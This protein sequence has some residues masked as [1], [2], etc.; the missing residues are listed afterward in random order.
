MLEAA[1]GVGLASVLAV[2]GLWSD[3]D[4]DKVFVEGC[5]DKER[6]YNV[7]SE[8]WRSVDYYIF[9]HIKLDL[10]HFHTHACPG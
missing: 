4:W 7:H 6:K 8:V 10:H 3:G 5:K 2:A 9:S 1:A